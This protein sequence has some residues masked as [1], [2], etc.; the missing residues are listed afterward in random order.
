ME[1]G[2]SSHSQMGELFLSCRTEEW[3]PLVLPTRWRSTMDIEDV[4]DFFMWC[5]IINAVLL[6]VTALLCTFAGGWIYSVHGKWY[7]MSR[8]AFNV[9]IYSFVGLYKILFIVFNLVP[10]LALVIAG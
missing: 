10:Y 8:E 6:V 9:V 4:R 7:P 2:K 3:K 1:R 5:T